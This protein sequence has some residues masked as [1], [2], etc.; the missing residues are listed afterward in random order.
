MLW[1]NIQ[2][3]K[4]DTGLK[5]KHVYPNV[6]KYSVLKIIRIKVFYVKSRI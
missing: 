1:K 4:Q 3:T 2:T 6:Y 5:L